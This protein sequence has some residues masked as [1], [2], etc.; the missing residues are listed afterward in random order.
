MLLTWSVWDDS[1]GEMPL[2]FFVVLTHHVLLYVH[3]LFQKIILEREDAGVSPALPMWVGYTWYDDEDVHV[4][5]IDM[6]K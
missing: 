1:K 4:R 2:G 5:G 3:V 6:C